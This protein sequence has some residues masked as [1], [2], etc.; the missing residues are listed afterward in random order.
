LYMCSRIRSLSHFVFLVQ[1]VYC[2]PLICVFFSDGFS[3]KGFE[4]VVHMKTS[5]ES[6]VLI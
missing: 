6:S 3:M 4:G 2:L 1:G 5:T